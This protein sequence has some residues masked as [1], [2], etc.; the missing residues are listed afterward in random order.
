M[1]L[2]IF[3]RRERD[4]VHGRGAERKGKRV[5]SRICADSRGPDVELEPM[6]HEIMTQAKVR[7]LTDRATQAP[8]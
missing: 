8:L 3:E 5:Q 2:F 7:C 4:S 1:F 6:N